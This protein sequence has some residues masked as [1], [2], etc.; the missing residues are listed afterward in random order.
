MTG[1]TQS[2]VLWMESGWMPEIEVLP[3]QRYSALRAEHERLVA[4]WRRSKLPSHK[5]E[6]C[7]FLAVLP[8]EFYLH[9]HELNEAIDAIRVRIGLGRLLTLNEEELGARSDLSYLDG[10]TPEEINEGSAL[11]QGRERQIIAANRR[12]LNA[13]NAEVDAVRRW[14]L[15]WVGDGSGTT[16][17]SEIA[18]VCPVDEQTSALAQA[19]STREQAA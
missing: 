7:E 6:L 11:R 12:E 9:K 17:L 3:W 8:R 19:F 4:Q 15:V 14:S 10:A 5:K 16:L 13:L 2:R 18:H 1:L